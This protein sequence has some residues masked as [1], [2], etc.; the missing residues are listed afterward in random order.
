VTLKSYTRNTVLSVLR[1]TGVFTRVS[2]SRRRHERLLILCF[3][4]VSLRDE[5]RWSGDLYVTANH[6]RRRLELL[7]SFQANVI[8]LGEGIERLRSHSLPP[9]SVAITFDD[10]FYDFYRQ[11]LP[12]IREFRYPCTVYLTTHYSDRSLPVFNLI[13]N[14]MLW[15]SG[16][17]EVQLPE[18]GIP[19]VM[20][21]RKREHRVEAVRA[22]LRCTDQWTTPQRDQAARDLAGRLKIDY[23]DLVGSRLLQ[24][25]SPEEVAA[26]AACGVS[27]EMHTHRHRTP[28][29]RDLFQREIHD[30]RTRI[31]ELTGREPQHFCYPSGDCAPEF[32]PWL[33]EMGVKS[34]TTCR[35]GL[36][37]LGSG[38][39]T[40]PRILDHADTSALDFE[41]WLCG[42]GV[43]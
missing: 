32:L 43:W 36:A 16:A 24:I 26:A 23:D 10:G 33:E 2:S 15:K 13:V 3:H 5:H 40:L 7:Q 34:A 19:D 11:A 39:L 28:R 20:S 41:S 17:R 37:G 22:I 9:R 31:Q 6:L 18:L 25:M 42:V 14:Y 29:D 8:P 1:R 4:G 27:F 21:V 12:L 30:N 38:L 35:R